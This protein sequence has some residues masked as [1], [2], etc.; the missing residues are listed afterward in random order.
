[1]NKPTQPKTPRQKAIASARSSAAFKA[2]RKQLLE[3]DNHCVICGNEAN[4]ID[5]IIE[6]DRFENPHDANTLENCQVMC[7]KCNSR[8][9][10]RYGN[11]KNGNTVHNQPKTTKSEPQFFYE[12]P[13]MTPDSDHSLSEPYFARLSEDSAKFE[14]IQPRLRTN[15]ESGDRA[16]LLDLEEF[17]ESVLNVKLM[18][19]QRLVLGDMLSIDPETGRLAFRQALCSVARQNGKSVALRVLVA[20]W[21]VRMVHIRGESQTVLTTAHRLDLATELFNSLAEILETKFDAKIVWSYG[22]QSATIDW[23]GGLQSR[24][25]VRAATPSAGHGLSVDL[26]VIDELFDC[27]P[28]AVDDALIPT[29]RARRDPLLAMWSTAGTSESEVMLRFRTRGMAEIDTKTKSRLYFCEY[30]PP[31]NLNPLSLE[32]AAWANPAR[33]ITVD[34]ETI[35][36]ELKNPNMAATLRS[37]CNLWITSSRSWLDNG[38]FESL[39]DVEEMPEGGV[40]SVEASSDDHRFVGVRAVSQGETVFATVEF[41]V[42][43][44][45][46]LWKS[47]EQ[48]KQQHKGLQIVI[49]ASLDLHLPT[50]LH[51]R[52]VLVGVKELQKWTILVRSMIMSKQVRHTGESLLVEQVDRA[53]LSKHNGINT[54]SSARSPGPI[55][56]CRALVWAVATAGKPKAKS[57]AAFASAK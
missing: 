38:L 22:R 5:H 53:V 23:G 47:I 20:W 15:T 3:Y 39:G 52:A 9:G 49:A 24:W 34:D 35:L 19:W 11:A 1:M 51:G 16:L 42:D 57:G 2:I 6:V 44:L 31:S 41:I 13:S 45:S 21:L 12:T 33:G 18:P 28:A 17:A 36:D 55:E 7:R 4:T 25:I 29:M 30:S 37:V 8:K 27:S 54:I 26:C 32:A 10:A 43:N 48:C 56:L 50:S 40:L 14:Q 46:D